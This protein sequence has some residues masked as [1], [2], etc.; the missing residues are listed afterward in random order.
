MNKAERMSRSDAARKRR[1]TVKEIIIERTF[2][3]YDKM[4]RLR[5]KKK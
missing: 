1:K 3:Y 4:R 2:H 5:K